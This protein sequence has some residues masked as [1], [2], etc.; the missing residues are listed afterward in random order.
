MGGMHR[1]EC[2]SALSQQ[3]NG[4]S[5]QGES[6]RTWDDIP[7]IHR[8]FIFDE[9]KP[10]HELNLCDFASSM[11]AEVVFDILLSS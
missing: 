3:R 4:K 9:T 2:Y 6:L 5:W 1:T 7:R 8:I 11:C 10:I